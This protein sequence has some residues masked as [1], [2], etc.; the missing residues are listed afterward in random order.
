MSRL[1]TG[2]AILWNVLSLNLG[3]FRERHVRSAFDHTLSEKVDMLALNGH[4]HTQP[5]G[6]LSAGTL[7][8]VPDTKGL[9]VAI[10][11]PETSWGDDLLVSRGR[12]DQTGWSFGFSAKDDEWQMESDTPIRT[13]TSAIYHEVSP[14]VFPAF[15]QTETASHYTVAYE[16]GSASRETASSVAKILRRL[17]RDCPEVQ[18]LCRYHDGVPDIR[19]GSISRSER[20]RRQMR[21]N[22]MRQRLAEIS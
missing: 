4:E 9:R 8:V 13:V 18:L 6:R 17:S 3:G 10:D 11:V 16:I 14:V 2:Y 7:S 1:V 15:P 19:V 21:L 5:I 20:S 12:R 22:V